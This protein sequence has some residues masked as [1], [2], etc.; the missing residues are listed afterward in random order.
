MLLTVYGTE[1]PILCR[2]AVKKVKKLLTHSL[3]GQEVLRT[4]ASNLGTLQ[5][6]RFLL[7]STNLAWKWLQID[8]DLS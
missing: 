2:C 8:T 3:Y 1:W 7:L 6:V 4:G 5:N